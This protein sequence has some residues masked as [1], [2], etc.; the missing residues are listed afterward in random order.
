VN[1]TGAEL[2]ALIPDDLKMSLDRVSFF[3]QEGETEPY[4]FLALDSEH[5]SVTVLVYRK[6]LARLIARNATVASRAGS[7]AS[8]D[9]SAPRSE[10]FVGKTRTHQGA[11]QR[12]T[13]FT[14]SAASREKP[15]DVKR[16]VRHPETGR[17][18]WPIWT[19]IA[20]R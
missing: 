16:R 5:G 6:E 14:N 12:L 11:K 8:P 2:K 1:I 3:K 20:A 17:L 9:P 10:Y 18:V 19:P 15:K 13:G 7:A 4:V